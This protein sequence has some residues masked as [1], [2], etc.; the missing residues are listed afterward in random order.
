MK[1]IILTFIVVLCTGLG[2][3]AQQL[4]VATYNLRNAN[5]G[6]STNGNG[7][8][9]RYPVI[10][11]L[12]QFHD[13]DIFGTQECKHHQLEDLTQA[14]PQYAYIGIGRDDGKQAGE[15]SAIF[16]KKD[17]FKV[18]DHGDFWLSTDTSRPNKGWDAALPRIC[19]WGIFKEK[20]SGFTFMFFNLHMDHVGVE[21]R[22]ESAKLILAKIKETGGKLPVILT[23]D[24]NVDQTNE[25]YL[26][27][28]D[29]GILRDS[30][31]AAQFRYATNGTFN[32][33]NPNLKTDSRIDHVFISKQFTVKKYGVLTDTYRSEV[34]ESQ[35]EI[36]SGNFPKEVSLH[37]YQ[38]RTP[39]D[40]FP[41]MV[42]LTYKK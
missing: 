19:T 17:K 1:K 7:W 14:M 10:A 36:K 2:I 32:S 4:N 37:K 29:S 16:Y 15:Y 28:H 23:G 30:Y 13:F 25:S 24:F 20:K 8:G 38:A 3:E 33:F 22:K 27:L 40:H 12:V 42:V 39:S 18:L 21:A 31:E 35:K 6:D 11:D 9:Q 5:R 26:L 41:V 34:S